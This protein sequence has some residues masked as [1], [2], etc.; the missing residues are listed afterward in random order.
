[1]PKDASARYKKLKE[2]TKEV[3]QNKIVEGIMH[4]EGKKVH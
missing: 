2:Y 3:D 4:S 1:M